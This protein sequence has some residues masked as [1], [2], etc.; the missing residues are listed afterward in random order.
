MSDQSHEAIRKLDESFGQITD[1]TTVNPEATVTADSEDDKKQPLSEDLHLTYEQPS[2]NDAPGQR[3]PHETTA[4]QDAFSEKVLAEEAF[5][6]A[7]DYLKL[8]K[9]AAEEKVEAK[10]E[11][12]KSKVEEKAGTCPAA[13]YVENLADTFAADPAKGF[14]EVGKIALMTIGGIAVLRAIFHRK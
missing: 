6:D 9:Q 13:R 4:A 1:R 11:E 5:D 3:V 8:Q 2:T 12:I 7:A 14:M 10:A